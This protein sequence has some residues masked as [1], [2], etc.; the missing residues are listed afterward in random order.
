MRSKILNQPIDIFS[1]E[2]AASLLRMAF[3]NPKQ[4]KVITL[5]PEMIVNSAKNVEFQ[6]AINN[7][8]LIIPDGTG[9]VWGYKLL[10][11]IQENKIERIPGIEFAEK[12]L[13]FAD[14]LKKKV[15][16]FGGSIEVNEKVSSILQDKYPHII[17]TKSIHG[18]QSEEKY[19]KI[20]ED[21]SETNPDLVLVALGS[22]KQEIWINQFSYL[23]PNSVLIGIGG[24]LDVWSGKVTRAPKKIREMNLEWLYRALSQPKR[25]TRILRSLPKYVCMIIKEKLTQ[26]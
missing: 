15:A 21:I 25:T 3:I 18:Y 19:Q 17:L 12:A 1:F 10:S 13:E 16:I 8:H 24:S 7:A 20:A 11:N 23:F 5:N 9:I 6:A 4:F 2:E 22:P 14:E 26:P